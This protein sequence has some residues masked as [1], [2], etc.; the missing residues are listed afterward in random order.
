VIGSRVAAMHGA[1]FVLVNLGPAKLAKQAA[2]F[3]DQ[4]AQGS[5][6]VFE[7]RRWAE[8]LDESPALPEWTLSYAAELGLE[9]R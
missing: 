9:R 5:Q 1:R 2:S 6:R 4:L 3:S 7:H 8:L